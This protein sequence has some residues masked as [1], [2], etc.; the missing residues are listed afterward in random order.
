MTF[1]VKKKIM[2]QIFL[3]HFTA[4]LVCY[5]LPTAVTRTVPSDGDPILAFLSAHPDKS[6]MQLVRNDTVL[7]DFH[8]DRTMPLASTV[9]IIIAIEYAEQSR[10]RYNQSR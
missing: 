6:S 8:A 3:N 10:C 2:R 4:A 5:G 9:K 7:A 1:L